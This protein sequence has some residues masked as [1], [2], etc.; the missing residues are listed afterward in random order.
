MLYED[1]LMQA[2]ESS[3][4]SASEKIIDIEVKKF[5]KELKIIRDNTIA[6]TMKN[7]RITSEENM[8]EGKINIQINYRG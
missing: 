2:V 1:A 6:Q 5:E 3:M 8:L 4:K 7:I